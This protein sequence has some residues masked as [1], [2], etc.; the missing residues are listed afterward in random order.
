[1]DN[2]I[3]QR[4]RRDYTN[5]P[6]IARA[7]GA[8]SHSQAQPQPMFPGAAQPHNS[9][10]QNSAPSQP[11]GR[12]PRS[13][14]PAAA[15]PT[16]RHSRRR[17]GRK[18]LFSLILICLIAAGGG[19]AWRLAKP[20]ASPV[21]ADIK[22]AVHFP[23]YYPEQKKLPAGYTLDASSFQQQESGV[24]IYNISH[25]GQHLSIS[26]EAQPAQNVI[27]GFIK[28]YIPLHNAYP[29]KLGQVLI[30]AYGKASDLHTLASLPVN[31]GP[32]LLISAPSDTK[33]SDLVQIVQALKT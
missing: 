25:G 6:L 10:S 33:Q 20:P 23:I 13:K 9:S 24:V 29:A 16:I 32:W 4:Y 26:E 14:H 18:L 19:A 2:D 5:Q 30:G 3:R 8:G 22:S 1:M 11:T 27:D 15:A 17:P 12:H 28:N 7:P 31:N 21:P